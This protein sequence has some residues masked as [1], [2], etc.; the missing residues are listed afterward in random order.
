MLQEFV[1][2]IS[3]ELSMD[4]FA[5]PDFE[6]PRTEK[7][8]EV[9]AFYRARTLAGRLRSA[10]KHE[11]CDEFIGRHGE[12]QLKSE[13]F[14]QVGIYYARVKPNQIIHM[15]FLDTIR[16]IEALGE[17]DKK[18]VYSVIA[19]EDVVGYSKD[20]NV[21]LFDSMDALARCRTVMNRIADDV[22]DEKKFGDSSPVLSHKRE[23][24]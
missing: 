22:A 17:H 8:F 15:E 21:S 3:Q 20:N 6:K 13:A 5:L 10:T 2:D 1:E 7:E 23:A 24:L 14:S 18:L 16:K 12:T 9:W 11:T 4:F 19:A